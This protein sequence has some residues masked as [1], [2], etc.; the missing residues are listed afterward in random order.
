MHI[1]IDA[2]RATPEQR[3]GTENYSLHLIRNLLALQRETPEHKL[4]LYF[5]QPPAPGLFPEQANCETKVM[6][7]R[8]LWTHARLS[9]EMLRH[10]PD[11]LFVP[12]HVLPV[13]HPKRSVVTIHDL[14]YLRYPGAHPFRQRL[15]LKLSTAH[16]ARA[17][18][19]IIAISENTKRD[20]V[21][22][23]KTDPDRIRVIP[24]AA[25]EEFR[26]DIDLKEVATLLHRYSIDREYILYVGPLHARKNVL[27]LIDA[28]A[29]LKTE[30]GAQPRLVIAGKKGWIPKEVMR[31]IAPVADSITLT[32]FISP[33][34][35]PLF[36][37]GASAFVMPSLFEGFGLPVLEAMA[38]GTPVIAARSS[39]L[40]EVAGDA[41][42]MVDPES[43][44]DIADAIERLAG[45][46]EL[47]REL[48]QKGLAR[49]KQ[50]S[51]QRTAAETMALL[52]EVASS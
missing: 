9:W 30:K 20:I 52:E 21:H 13:I 47:Q 16:N 39:S 6:P 19:R 46:K 29:L 43:V 8:H 31:H 27:R 35:L 36:Y 24:L 37:A 2:S 41:A 40:P 50:F 12:A 11:V 28:L 15:Y 26:P 14:G 38:C 10:A 7:R 18:T 32:G 4:T 22:Y 51:W 17:A 33:Q 44:R 34:E 49:A 45:D 5:N 48:R 42:L 1:G 23:L 25:S 3:M